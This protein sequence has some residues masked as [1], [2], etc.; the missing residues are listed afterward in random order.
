MAE[1]VDGL[2]VVMGEDGSLADV[3]G[4]VL[5]D[6]GQQSPPAQAKSPSQPHA[7]QPLSLQMPAEVPQTVLPDIAIVPAVQADVVDSAIALEDLPLAD[8]PPAPD[9]DADNMPTAAA[10]LI[11]QPMLPPTI[12]PRAAEPVPGARTMVAAPAPSVSEIAANPTRPAPQQPVAQ[13]TPS[14]SNPPPTEN[15]A[16]PT[17]SPETPPSA[18]EPTPTAQPVAVTQPAASSPQQPTDRDAVLPPPPA[19]PC[20]PERE[21]RAKA[22]TVTATVTAATAPA[23]PPVRTPV[24]STPTAT[25]TDPD[26]PQTEPSTPVVATATDTSPPDDTAQTT[27][28][29]LGETPAPRLHAPTH[30][31]DTPVEPTLPRPAHILGQ[32]HAAV[33]RSDGGTIEINLSPSELGRVTIRLDAAPNE[34]RIIIAAERPETLALLKTHQAEL[35]TSLSN[36]G[37]STV[38]MT[39]SDRQPQPQ[40]Q[41]RAEA[42]THP[43]DD[44][45]DPAP[46]T[47]PRPQPIPTTGR[48]DRRI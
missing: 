39:F 10:P 35:A 14:S 8:T 7:P 24:I 22:P 25:P 47:W 38:D 4:Q 26:A 2:L 13:Q 21:S 44:Q 12:L 36:S 42:Q 15:S 23:A 20:A 41:S 48:Y 6:L 29:P 1:S 19:T 3:F 30:I 43:S 16:Q 9:D 5:A 17:A 18:K 34:A 37:Y 27:P 28:T 40:S 46:P 45:P 32:I 31:R 11:V 33:T